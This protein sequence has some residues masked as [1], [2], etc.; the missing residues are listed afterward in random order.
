MADNIQF[1]GNISGITERLDQIIANQVVI[2]DMLLRAN[3]TIT[4]HPADKLKG[5]SKKHINQNRD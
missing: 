1:Q 4:S 5:E 2:Y 3:G